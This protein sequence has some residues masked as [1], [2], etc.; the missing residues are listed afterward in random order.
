MRFSEEDRQEEF[1]DGQH[2]QRRHPFAGSN[3]QPDGIARTR[4]ADDL[5]GRDIG[6]DQRGPNGPPRQAFGSVGIVRAV[7]FVPSLF[8]A[9][10][11]R[12]AENYDRMDSDHDD[13]DGSQSHWR[14]ASSLRFCFINNIIGQ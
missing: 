8:A 11:L 2:C 9:D 12:Q 7:L 3:R 13:I 1:A 10:E 5:F 14:P 6:R 4:H